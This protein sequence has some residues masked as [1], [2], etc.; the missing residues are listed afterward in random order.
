MRIQVDLFGVAVGEAMVKAG[1]GRRGRGKCGRRCLEARKDRCVCSC[2]GRNHGVLNRA[3]NAMLDGDERYI[4]LDHIPEIRR[5][6]EGYACLSCG[7][8][9]DQAEILGYEHPDGLYVESYGLRLWV[10]ARC[11]RCGYDSSWRKL[12][13]RKKLVEVREPT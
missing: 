13:N 6:F 1:A 11:R 4:Y 12:Q 7:A 2:G 8:T 9:F 5:L 10:F 3:K